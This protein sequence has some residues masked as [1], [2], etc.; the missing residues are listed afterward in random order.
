[1]VLIEMAKCG[2]E[3]KPGIY[4]E[5]LNLNHSYLHNYRGRKPKIFRVE[6]VPFE[7]AFKIINKDKENKENKEIEKVMKSEIQINLDE[8]ETDNFLIEKIRE[9][10]KNNGLKSLV[11]LSSAIACLSHTK[12][13]EIIFELFTN[14]INDVIKNTKKITG[15]KEPEKS[16]KKSWQVRKVPVEGKFNIITISDS[17]IQTVWMKFLGDFHNI[18]YHQKKENCD[19]M[20]KI[21]KIDIVEK[22]KEF[23]SQ[24]FNEDT[25]KLILFH[26]NLVSFALKTPNTKLNL[27]TLLTNN[28]LDSISQPKLRSN[29]PKSQHESKSEKAIY[30]ITHV[31]KSIY[32]S[33]VPYTMHYNYALQSC[34]NASEIDDLHY[35]ICL[36]HYHVRL[37]RQKNY[38]DVDTKK[39]T[40]IMPAIAER[41]N[42][43]SYLLLIHAMLNKNREDEDEY[44]TERT[45]NRDKRARLKMKIKNRVSNKNEY[46][47]FSLAVDFAHKIRTN[48]HVSG[49][50]GN[51]IDDDYWKRKYSN[52]AIEKT[53]QK[54]FALTVRNATYGPLLEDDVH[55]IKNLI[56]YDP[57]NFN[58]NNI[59][60]NEIYKMDANGI[61]QFRKDNL[62][63]AISIFDTISVCGFPHPNYNYQNLLVAILSL[64]TETLTKIEKND[65]NSEY[66]NFDTMKKY[67]VMSN[68]NNR[69]GNN[70]N[71]NNNDD[72]NNANN[73][74]DEYGNYND[75][76]NDNNNNNNNNNNG[77]DQIDQNIENY[78]YYYDDD[79]YYEDIDVSKKDEKVRNILMSE[80]TIGEDSLEY[81]EQ[82]VDLFEG[83]VAVKR[84]SLLDILLRKKLL[85]DVINSKNHNL[86][87]RLIACSPS[88]FLRSSRLSPNHVKTVLHSLSELGEYETLVKYFIS[89]SKSSKEEVN[90]IF[91]NMENWKILANSLAILKDKELINKNGN[92]YNDNIN[93][94]DNNENEENFDIE[95]NNKNI[96]KSPGNDVL[97][98]QNTSSNFLNFLDRKTTENY[99]DENEEHERAEI[100]KGAKYEI[101]EIDELIFTV[102]DNLSEIR[103]FVDD[104]DLVRNVADILIDQNLLR[105]TQFLLKMAIKDR[106][107]F[108]TPPFKNSEYHRKSLKN[109]WQK[110]ET[111]EGIEDEL[112]SYL[113][114]ISSRM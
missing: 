6:K 12:N 8:Q 58:V 33:G 11:N 50:L 102:F 78:D 73:N 24:Y 108:C 92:E 84:W 101:T 42:A 41:P 19:K 107:K 76:M 54:G 9:M 14:N 2:I 5:I 17:S 81:L 29:F 70:N 99:D 16:S 44:S 36:M 96:K 45:R 100:K 3:P 64:N 31:P 59:N 68:G 34:H 46:D 67:N 1:M 103:F 80:N 35:L 56:N 66:S 109:S 57:N 83:I 22:S 61:M 55:T 87:H 37:N 105:H 82:A 47:L 25:L 38:L 97:N 26:S 95:M 15:I 65:N 113:N 51:D 85:T 86:I 77:D 52:F 63:D 13:K 32:W 111:L 21:D 104:D 110:N 75:N 20:N 112:E 72:N 60:K 49:A 90:E 48:N 40:A 23:L 106:N 114:F 39:E 10:N 7:N 93:N 30:Q 27:P 28:L 69:C 74:D 94:I 43:T 62:R 18:C 88:Y 91:L 71:N 79:Y 53:L 89:F 4:R 98:V